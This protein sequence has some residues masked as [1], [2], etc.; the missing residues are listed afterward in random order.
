MWVNSLNTRVGNLEVVFPDPFPAR[1]DCLIGF[2][3][4]AL[5]GLG[6]GF[7]QAGFTHKIK[8]FWVAHYPLCYQ[9]KD[10]RRFGLAYSRISIIARLRLVSIQRSY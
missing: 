3:S 8:Q 2:V 10:T 7:G 5:H 9:A 1:L 4:R 6:S